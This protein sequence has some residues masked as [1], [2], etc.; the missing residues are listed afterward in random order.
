[1]SMASVIQSRKAHTCT[2]C[3]STIQPGDWYEIAYERGGNWDAIR[4]CSRCLEERG[5]PQSMAKRQSKGA[6]RWER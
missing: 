1:M 5:L 4:T 6:L 3:G 2:T